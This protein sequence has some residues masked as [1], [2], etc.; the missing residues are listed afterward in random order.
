MQTK[1]RRKPP[2]TA[3]FTKV[4]SLGAPV[5]TRFPVRAK[6]GVREW[7][8]RVVLCQISASL[9]YTV[10]HVGPKPP[11]VSDGNTAALRRAL[12]CQ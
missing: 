5:A 6:C 7:T 8:N 1:K 11:R 4:S 2:E 3:I 9:V 10:T 12:C